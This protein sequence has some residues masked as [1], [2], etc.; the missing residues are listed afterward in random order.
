[1]S[2]KGDDIYVVWR[3]Y[4][5]ED[6]AVRIAK[7]TGYSSELT[8][9]FN[10]SQTKDGTSA[11]AG[12][13]SETAE[14]EWEI[15]RGDDSFRKLRE[16]FADDD[17]TREHDLEFWEIHA[18]DTNEQGEYFA[19]YRIANMESLPMEAPSGEAATASMSLRIWQI[20]QPG[21]TPV[22]TELEAIM[23]YA[24]KSIPEAEGTE[25]EGV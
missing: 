1:M 22:D 10:D 7:Q 18:Y 19:Y 20:G 13:P 21:Y 4:A 16:I 12:R 25:T 11:T 14:V 17:S 5:G 2:V 3:D 6:P 9:D 8:K 24:F 15:A 23:Q